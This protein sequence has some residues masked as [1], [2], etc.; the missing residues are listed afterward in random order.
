MRPTRLGVTLGAAVLL[1]S[2]AAGVNFTKPPD[3]ALVFGSTTK[4]QIISL[5]GEPNGKGQK[6]SN[7]EDLDV[8]GYSYARVGG[9]AVFEDVTPARS[10]AFYFHR[11]VLVGSESTSSFKAD[12][13]YFD[14]EKARALKRGMA[15]T[16]V[17]ALLGNP[18]GEYRYPVTSSPDG[19]ALVYTFV[20]TKGFKSQRAT[21]IVELD[22]KGVVQK[23]DFSQT[24]QL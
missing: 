3:D 22:E 19:K 4:A 18:G 6:V 21:L 14:P 9:E 24:G 17:V 20:Q 23:V 13:T 2:C 11:D 15:A 12:S 5:M 1:A 16:D 7:G 8:I 10:V